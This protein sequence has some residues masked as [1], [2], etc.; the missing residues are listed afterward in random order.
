MN[1]TNFNQP[2]SVI[3]NTCNQ[4][5]YDVT[6]KNDQIPSTLPN[7]VIVQGKS[8][9]VNATN[10]T[11]NNYRPLSQRAAIQ[12]RQPHNSKSLEDY[13]VENSGIKLKD[14]IKAS[15]LHNVD[16]EVSKLILA[17]KCFNGL[18]L[19]VDKFGQRIP[20][21]YKS[22]YEALTKRPNI[23]YGQFLELSEKTSEYIINTS[24]R[25][26]AE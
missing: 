26:T 10:I 18:Q 1:K 9:Q 22:I 6:D 13:I 12:H 20:E 17:I 14:L 5:E 19:V 7:T 23:T 4:T 3:N 8:D 25:R 15:D 16:P 21:C 24:W 11:R 2:L